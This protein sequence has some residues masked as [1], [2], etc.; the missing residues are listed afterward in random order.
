MTD[1]WKK[2]IHQNRIFVLVLVVALVMILIYQ[3]SASANVPFMDYWKYIDRLVDKMYTQGVSFNDLYTS[4]GVHRSPIQ[5]FIFLCNVRLFHYNAQIEVYLGGMLLGV[6]GC[7]LYK[8]LKKEMQCRSSNIW[9]NIGSICIV[10]LLFNLN[11]WEILSDEF[12][13]SFVLRLMAFEL[14]FIITNNYLKNIKKDGSYAVEIAMLYTFTICGLSG[15]FFLAYG[16]ALVVVIIWDF[17]RRENV[18]KKR[19]LKYYIIL[20]LGLF[21]GAILYVVGLDMNTANGTTSSIGIS[22]LVKYFKAIVIMLGATIMG[23]SASQTLVIICGLGLCLIYIGSVILYFYKKMYK[24]TYLPILFMTYSLFIIF[25]I[26]MGRVQ[27]GFDYLC[28]S[29]YV[30]DTQLGILA[31]IWIYC[32]YLKGIMNFNKQN[33]CK[34]IIMSI[35]V[36]ILGGIAYAD[37]NEWGIKGYRKE[38]YAD[39]NNLMLN[40]ENLSDGELAKCQADPK[41]VRESV[42]IMKKYKIGLYQYYK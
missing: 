26:C 9:L 40:I 2:K 19:Y 29:R 11:Q 16:G 34:I 6:L 20:G 36:I 13:F 32:I 25:V 21:L 18:E 8:E 24:K 3:S 37:I 38:Y 28:S 33:M 23:T 42:E 1:K 5:L 22:L 15:A 35:I 27:Y 12:A 39:I 31:C 14:S 30:G 10:A 41:S 7:V 4:N 17:L